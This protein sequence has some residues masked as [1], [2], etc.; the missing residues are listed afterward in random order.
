M[1]TKCP[2]EVFHLFNEGIA[3]AILRG[4]FQK[5]DTKE[6]R[7]IFSDLNDI[8]LHTK[9]FSE[10]PRRPRKIKISQLKGNELYVLSFVIF[11][12]LLQRLKKRKFKK[13]HW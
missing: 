4:L 10:T 7:E 5:T 13:P 1:I 9:V 11:P 2:P 6:S 8:Y 12:A 3:K